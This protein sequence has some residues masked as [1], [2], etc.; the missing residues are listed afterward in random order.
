NQ[1][2]SHELCGD[3]KE[4]R[5]IL[6]RRPTLIHEP[7]IQ[8]VDQCRRIE[9]VIAVFAAKLLSCDPPAFGVDH[10]HQAVEGARI[11]LRPSNQETGNVARRRFALLHRH[12][13]PARASRLLK[14]GSW[15]SGAYSGSTAR[16]AIAFDR[17]A[18]AFS[19]IIMASS[20]SPSS[21][22]TCAIGA[23]GT[24]W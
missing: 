22:K 8:F 2:P 18:N 15:R 21:A 24:Y 17:S 19:I 4:L 5:P 23:A 6:P 13:S 1:N 10:R 12:L 16:Y 20:V 14:R 9:R 7:Q 11:A 3:A